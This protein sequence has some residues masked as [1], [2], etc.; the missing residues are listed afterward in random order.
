MF[1]LFQLGCLVTVSLSNS[2]LLTIRTASFQK[3]CDIEFSCLKCTTARICAPVAGGQSFEEIEVIGTQSLGVTLTR[4]PARLMRP[5]PARSHRQRL[6]LHARRL[7]P[8][9][10]VG[11]GPYIFQCL[12][13]K[14][15]YVPHYQ[16][17]KFPSSKAY[18]ANH[19]SPCVGLNGRK[20]PEVS[21][22][23]LSSTASEANHSQQ[24]DASVPTFSTMLPKPVYRPVPTLD[25]SQAT[26][27][28]PSTTDALQ[29]Q[30]PLVR[31]P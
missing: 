25:C 26:K 21:T 3:T 6:H 11:A 15:N 7:L 8:R 28:A 1:I 16:A 23:N 2:E 20:A 12:G 14:H 31:L 17:C 22:S 19:N 18:C 10:C 4:V 24:T 13:K 9:H 27:T 29:Q 30:R 5:S